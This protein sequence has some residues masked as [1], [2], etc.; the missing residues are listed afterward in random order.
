MQVSCSVHLYDRLVCIT[1]AYSDSL[2]IEVSLVHLNFALQNVQR[3]CM[4]LRRM[5]EQPRQ[6]V[7]GS[8]TIAAEQRLNSMIT[9]Q[10]ISRWLNLR[11]SG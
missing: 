10:E 4:S 3:A 9:F 1:S 5:L 8:V 6:G 11:A 2:P 7:Y